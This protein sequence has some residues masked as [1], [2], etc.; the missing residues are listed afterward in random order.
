MKPELVFAFS[1]IAG[2]VLSMLFYAFLSV[3]A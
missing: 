1:L 2:V 3:V